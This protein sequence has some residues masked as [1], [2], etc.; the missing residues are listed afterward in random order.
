M[1]VSALNQLLTIREYLVSS[2]EV[3]CDYVDGRV[4]ERHLG[5][6]DHGKIQSLFDRWF[7]NH[8]DEWGIEVVVEQRVEVSPTRFRVPD[9]CVLR[10]QGPFEQI[11][12]TPPLICIEVLSPEDT[13]SRL[14]VKVEDYLR[15]GVGNVWVVDPDSR[16]AWVCTPEGWTH[17]AG[18]RFTVPGTEIYVSMDGIF[19]A[20]D[21]ARQGGTT[22]SGG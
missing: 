15:M 8:D 11:V 22:D 10:R 7:G 3:D 13:L 16:L 5:E 21:K 2:F 14:G 19:G 20:L 6:F 9:V 1:A 4:E 17:P 18:G 12:R